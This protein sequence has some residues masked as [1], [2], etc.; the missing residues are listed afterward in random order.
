MASATKIACAES[1]AFLHLIHSVPAQP[2]ANA[3][4]SATCISEHHT[5]PF[6]RERSLTSS[7]A[8]LSSI[9]DD[10]NH[11]SAI[12]VQED[13]KD[14]CLKVLIAVNE[15]KWGDSRRILRDLKHGF[16]GIFSLLSLMS[17]SE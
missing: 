12:C 9:N 10:P 6:E 16:E 3:I 2:S 14:R 11:V 4:D 1:I 7:L 17:P 13:S 15:A 5:L 8:F